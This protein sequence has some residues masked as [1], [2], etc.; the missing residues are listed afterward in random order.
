MDYKTWTREVF[1]AIDSMDAD[2][3]ASVF[4]D[5]ASFKFG[6]G[7]AVV[8]KEAIREY[9]AGFFSSIDGISHDIKT[10]VM[11]GDYL[12]CR[13]EVTYIRHDSSRLTAPFADYVKFQDGQAAE[14]QVYTDISALHQAA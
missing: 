1:Q 7:D 9:V 3:F 13:G 2:K 14:Y 10:I 11:N 4:A 6:N 8:G 5:N 12:V